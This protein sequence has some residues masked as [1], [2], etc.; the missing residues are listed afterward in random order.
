MSWKVEKNEEFGFI[1][2]V[3]MGELTKTDVQESTAKA[4]SLATETG[5]NLF[6]SDVTGARVWLSAFDI[7]DI[8]DQWN[9]EGASRKNRLAVVA[10]DESVKPEDS[11]FFKTVSQNRGWNVCIF[12]DR[13]SAIAWLIEN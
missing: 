4:L 9:A 5:Q 6:L 7:Y 13:Q 2:T 12:E 10:T 8:P 11:R 3:Y 1:E